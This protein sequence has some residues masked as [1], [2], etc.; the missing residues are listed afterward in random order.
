MINRVAGA[1]VLTFMI[2]VILFTGAV[3]WRLHAPAHE[4]PVPVTRPL[5]LPEIC[6]KLY[7][8]GRHKE[9]IECM[10]VGPK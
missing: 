3:F 4:M 7:D 1:L 2:C 5:S 9:W 6:Q 8:V 10:G